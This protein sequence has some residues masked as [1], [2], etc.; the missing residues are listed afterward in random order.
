MRKTVRTT[1]IDTSDAGSFEQRRLPRKNVLFSGVLISASGETGCD[2]II[3]D[4]HASGAAISLS[5]PLQVG[6][7][8]FLLDIANAAAHDA[9]IAWT[10]ADRSGLS[11][12]RNYAMGL[13]LPPALRFLWRFL[14]EARLSQA[15]RTIASGVDADLACGTAGL[16]REYI[17]Q[18][19]RY[20]SS[21]KRLLQLLQRAITLLDD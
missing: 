12:T 16:T 9:R 20:A 13:G 11:F 15:E 10:R 19:S 18:M 17:H 1:L 3:R 2:C 5:R 14:F 4:M 8:V 7:R 6:S 21:D